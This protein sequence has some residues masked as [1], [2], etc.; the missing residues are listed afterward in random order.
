MIQRFNEK[1]VSLRDLI[2]GKVIAMLLFSFILEFKLIVNFKTKINLHFMKKYS[3]PKATNSNYQM[4]NPNLIKQICKKLLLALQFIYSKGLFY[5]HL[6]SGNVLVEGTSNVRL[7]DLPNGLLG[8]PYL[9]RSYV[10]EQRKIQV[11]KVHLKS[12]ELLILDKQ[13]LNRI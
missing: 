11:N 3:N 9:Y 10:I 13:K 1:T 2:Y 5:G 4:M 6:H 7:T 12:V 8:L